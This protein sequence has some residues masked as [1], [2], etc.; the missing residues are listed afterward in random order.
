MF[1]TVYTKDSY[2]YYRKNNKGNLPD[3]D[4]REGLPVY[5]GIVNGYI[6]RIASRVLEGYDVRVGAKL[7]TIG[8]RGEKV[9][10]L[11]ND[12]GEVKGIAPNW[13]ETKKLQARDPEAKKNR[14]I[15]YCFNEHSNGIKYSFFWSKENVIV[16]NKTI[17]GLAMSRHN[18]REVARLVQEE[19][20]EY[21]IQS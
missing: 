17:Y 11:I 14:T 21:L 1:R 7:G 12:K 16:K 5:M 19:G 4:Y 2:T 8:I 9:K 18:R 13:G 15:V 6:E 20:K 3:L 10:P